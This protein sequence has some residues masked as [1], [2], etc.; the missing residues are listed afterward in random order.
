RWPPRLVA[1]PPGRPDRRRLPE[2]EEI[3]AARFAAA[4]HDG[5]VGADLDLD[6]AVAAHPSR[7]RAPCLAPVPPPPHRSPLVADS[8]PLREGGRP[9]P[10]PTPRTRRAS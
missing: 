7:A 3:H 2:R 8:Y 10:G 4:P 9:P 1:G 6:G 5:A